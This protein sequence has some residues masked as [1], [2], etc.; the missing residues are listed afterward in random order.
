MQNSKKI[1]RKFDAKVLFCYDGDTCTVQKSPLAPRIRIRLANID[2]PERARKK[3]KGQSY[4]EESKKHIESWIHNQWVEVHVHEADRYGRL[5]ADLYKKT[6]EKTLHINAEMIKNGHAFAYRRAR[7]QKATNAKFAKLEK[8]SQKEKLGMW[9]LS[10]EN[11]PLRP[12]KFRKS[13]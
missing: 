6:N 7:S 9:R 10:P 4:A 8:I 13:H 11:R 2:A 3:K 12:E 1:A 5:V